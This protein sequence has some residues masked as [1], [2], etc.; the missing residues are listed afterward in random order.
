MLFPNDFLF[1]VANAPAQVEDSDTDVWVRFAKNGGVRAWDVPHAEKRLSFWSEPH[2]EL[3]L[4]K[5]LG[6]RAFRLGIDWG[7]LVPSP[8]V[9]DEAAL[10]RYQEIIS[11]VR[12]RG[13][14]PF[15]T[16]FHHTVPVWFEDRGGWAH[17]E[18]VEDF[19]AFFRFVFRELHREGSY[20]IT[21]NEPVPWAFLTYH[22]G[23]FSP[24]K[25]RGV[26][27]V[28]QALANMKESHGAFYRYAHSVDPGVKVGIAHNMAW[29]TGR[30]FLNGLIGKITGELLNWWFVKN[31]PMDYF[32]INYYGSEWMTLSGPAEFPELEYSDAGRAVY[33]EGLYLL[34]RTIAGK[35][36][37]KEI[38]VTENGVGDGTDDMRRA[39]L[40]EHLVAV[41][42]AISDGIPVT[43]YM[44]WSLTDNFEWADGYGPKFGLVAV[45]RSD[46]LKRIKRPSFEMYQK[47][48]SE[49]GF[50]ESFRNEVWADYK[51]S[52][53]RTRPYWRSENG[54]HALDVARERL[55]PDHDWKMS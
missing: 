27:T 49:N 41:H 13:M 44:Q 32:G 18:A 2:I 33:P 21:L 30:G 54:I 9:F 25:K 50:T 46:G 53:G 5:D 51:K 1:G 37:D 36:P 6:V 35:F 8:G 31:L 39:Y 42:R 7:R 17:P 45:D 38:V 26:K 23:L 10:K 40:V 4:A 34:L 22:A 43:G 47:I 55:T 48:I 29:Y 28:I 14:V 19:T 12:E 16:L 15:I 3:D 52:V 20:W 11:G 24:G